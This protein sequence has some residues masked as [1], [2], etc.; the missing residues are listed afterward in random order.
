MWILHHVRR[1][2]FDGKMVM[3]WRAI[4]AKTFK[5]HRRNIKLSVY[6]AKTTRDKSSW[7][8]LYKS[9]TCACRC[10]SL[11]ICDCPF[12]CTSRLIISLQV[13]LTNNS[14]IIY[15]VQSL[16]NLKVCCNYSW[17]K[18][19]YFPYLIEILVNTE[20]SF[21]SYIHFKVY[22]PSHLYISHQ[23]DDIDVITVIWCNVCY[24]LT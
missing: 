8:I 17:S 5:C 13:E 24:M 11:I 12:I 16:D 14:K 2:T 18:R 4:G 3:A 9:T 6:S 15:L 22:Q 7:S 20:H 19:I 1:F 23:M 10:M 21:A